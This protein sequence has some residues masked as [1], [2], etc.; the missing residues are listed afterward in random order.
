LAAAGLKKLPKHSGMVFR[1][2]NR[3]AAQ[4][5]RTYRESEEIT[6]E[7]FTSTATV[8]EKAFP[9]TVR[10]RIRANGTSGRDVQDFA[11]FGE[12]EVLFAPGARFKV[13]SVH[14]AEVRR[15]KQPWFIV[16]LVEL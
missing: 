11:Q 10:L 14:T 12:K 9:G 13:K 2:E 7:G 5:A 6:L 16:E 1:G 3:T 15:P 4:V 8:E